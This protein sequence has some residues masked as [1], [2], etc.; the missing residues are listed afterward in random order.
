MWSHASCNNGIKYLEI[1]VFLF[2]FERE[3]RAF[4]VGGG[5]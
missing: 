3:A 5:D 2:G 1:F 4:V